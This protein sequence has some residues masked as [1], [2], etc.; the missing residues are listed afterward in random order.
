M[1]LKLSKTLKR[2]TAVAL[3]IAPFSLWAFWKPIR[4]LAPEWAGVVCYSGDVCTDDPSTAQEALLLRIEAISFVER[5]A[6]KFEASP[7]IIFC[8]SLACEKSFGFNGNAAYHF[9]TKALIVASHGWKPYIIRHELI[10]SV[11]VERIGGFR[12]LFSTPTWLIEGM[13][14]SASEDPRKPLK[15]P[16]ETYRRSYEHWASQFPPEEL[17][18]RTRAL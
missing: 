5:W 3:L 7:R 6:G 15:E 12:M 9:G 10:H 14:Y 4:T 1:Y 11:Q 13:A 8:T 17:W 18:S 16:W 2:M